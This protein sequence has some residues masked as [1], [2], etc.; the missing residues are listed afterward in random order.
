MEMLPLLERFQTAIV[1]VIGFAGVIL[2]LVDNA[3]PNF[4]D[5]RS[6][7]QIANRSGRNRGR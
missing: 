6:L 2:T 4:P 1:G 3:L 5:W 7:E